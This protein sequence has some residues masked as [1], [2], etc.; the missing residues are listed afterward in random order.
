MIILTLMVIAVV[1]PMVAMMVVEVIDARDTKKTYEAIN[2]NRRPSKFE[3]AKFSTNY[4][5]H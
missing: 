5:A 3:G 1:F 2:A 4:K